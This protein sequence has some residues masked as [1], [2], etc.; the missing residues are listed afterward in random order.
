MG[1]STT[2]Q[3][4]LIKHLLQSI[5]VVDYSKSYFKIKLEPKKLSRLGN[6]MGEIVE[7]YSQVYTRR[8]KRISETI[9]CHIRVFSV[10]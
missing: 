1:Y 4:N 6:S 2:I 9:M 10:D 5:V 3:I 8:N 7:D